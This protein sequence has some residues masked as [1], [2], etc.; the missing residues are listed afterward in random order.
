[1]SLISLSE[2]QKANFVDKV[3]AKNLIKLSMFKKA[4]SDV[5][6]GKS[7]DE[8]LVDFVIG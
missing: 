7:V 8:K 4:L 5:Q 6:A 3:A 1:M 2:E